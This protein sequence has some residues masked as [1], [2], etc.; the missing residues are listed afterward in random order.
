MA[1]SNSK[2]FQRYLSN[3]IG[4]VTAFDYDADTIKVALYN[5]TTAPDNDVAT[6]V[7]TG[8]NGAASQWVVANEVIDSSG[9]G[10][11]WPAGGLTLL[12][13]KQ[14]FPFYEPFGNY[15]KKAKVLP[16][17]EALKAYGPRI[18]RAWTYMALNR[19]LQASAA[20]IMKKAMVDGWEAGIYD[21]SVL[22]APLLT[23]HDETDHS[24]PRTK[25]GEEAMVEAKRLMET[26]FPELKVPLVCDRS[27]GRNW[28]E[29]S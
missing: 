18:T 13:R 6:D 28:G 4:N 11:D 19:K 3:R 12:D 2:V 24:K 21:P 9:G 27:S 20:D 1:W 15:D 29:A 5:T 14:R 10:T 8:Y 7:L 22:G 25:I 16:H 26:G 17:E 23:V